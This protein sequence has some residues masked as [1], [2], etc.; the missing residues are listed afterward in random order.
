MPDTKVSKAKPGSFYILGYLLK[1]I[2][3]IWQF[4]FYFSFQLLANLNHFFS[5]KNPILYWLKSHF[6]GQIFAEN[7][8]IRKKQ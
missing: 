5:M 2:V 4:E 7:L 3:E 8:P 6:S 1:L